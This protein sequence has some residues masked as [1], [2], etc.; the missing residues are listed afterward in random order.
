MSK[1]FIAVGFGAACVALILAVFVHV[2]PLRV[3]VGFA[4]AGAALIGLGVL[5]P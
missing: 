2:A 1:F 5:V 3:D 4:A